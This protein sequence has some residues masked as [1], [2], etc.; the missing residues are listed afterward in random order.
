M[1]PTDLSVVGD[2]QLE[3]QLTA[4]A[5]EIGLRTAR[6]KKLENARA[7]AEARATDLAAATEAAASRSPQPP[8]E[9]RPTT[10]V[11]ASPGGDGAKATAQA[12]EPEPE[13]DLS[14]E[15]PPRSRD[16][17]QERIQAAAERATNHFIDGAAV[18]VYQDQGPWT[19]EIVTVITHE[20]RLGGELRVAFEGKTYSIPSD[21]IGRTFAISTVAIDDVEAHFDRARTGS[22]E[23]NATYSRADCDDARRNLSFILDQATE[24]GFDPK[25]VV[26]SPFCPWAIK[27]RVLEMGFSGPQGSLPPETSRAASV[28][29]GC[30]TAWLD[31]RDSAARERASSG[32]PA[33]PGPYAHLA[34]GR[35][36]PV[37]EAYNLR[38]RLTMNAM[39]K[40]L[41]LVQQAALESQI[42]QLSGRR[43]ELGESS[44]RHALEETD[45]TTSFEV[46][47]SAD[48]SYNGATTSDSN[49]TNTSS[50]GTEFVSAGGETTDDSRPAV[51]GAAAILAVAK[52]GL[53]SGNDHCV[54]CDDGLC[55]PDGRVDHDE[56]RPAEAMSVDG[57]CLPCASDALRDDVLCA[58]C[59][60]QPG[61][62]GVCTGCDQCCIDAHCPGPMTACAAC[63]D[64]HPTDDL[65]DGVC[66]G[67]AQAVPCE[68]CGMSFTQSIGRE[69]VSA[70]YDYD[71]AVTCSDCLGLAERQRQLHEERNRRS[72]WT[73]AANR[74]SVAGEPGPVSQR[75]GYTAEPAAASRAVAAM[76]AM[77]RAETTRPDTIAEAA[78]VLATMNDYAP[79]FLDCYRHGVEWLLADLGDNPSPEGRYQWTRERTLQWKALQSMMRCKAGLSADPPPGIARV[80]AR[81]MLVC[82]QGHVLTVRHP[83]HGHMLPGGAWIRGG[84][85]W[86]NQSGPG[87]ASAGIEQALNL[88][89][90]V[91]GLVYEALAEPAAHSF[92]LAT[93]ANPRAQGG[94]TSRSDT[95]VR[96]WVVR[97]PTRCM[98]AC[99]LRAHE[100]QP[101]LSLF[102]TPQPDLESDYTLGVHRDVNR[103][104]H[105]LDAVTAVGIDECSVHVSRTVN[106]VATL[107][108]VVNQIMHH[109]RRKS[110]LKYFHPVV[111]ADANEAALW[112]LAVR[113]PHN[114]LSFVLVE[115]R[116]L[117]FVRVSPVAA[118]SVEGDELSA[119]P[120]PAQFS[121]DCALRDNES[122][123]G[124]VLRTLSWLPAVVMK[125]VIAAAAE[126]PMATDTPTVGGVRKQK[127]VY[128]VPCW[129]HELVSVVQ[130]S[131][132]AVEEP[133]DQ[134]G[135]G[136]VH[137]ALCTDAE[138]AL[139]SRELGPTINRALQYLP[140]MVPGS[141]APVRA[142]PVFNGSRGDRPL[143]DV[144]GIMLKELLTK[145]DDVVCWNKECNH[146]TV[147]LLDAQGRPRGLSLFCCAKCQRRIAPAMGKSLTGHDE[148]PAGE[149]WVPAD[150]DGTKRSVHWSER[151][152]FASPCT[153][154]AVR[155][156]LPISFN[157]DAFTSNRIGLPATGTGVWK[158][159]IANLSNYD[160]LGAVYRLLGARF[161]VPE[162]S[163][164]ISCVANEPGLGCGCDLLDCEVTVGQTIAKAM[165]ISAQAVSVRMVGSRQALLN[166]QL[167]GCRGR[168][169]Y[170]G[171]DPGEWRGTSRRTSQGSAGRT[172]I[173]DESG[174]DQCGRVCQGAHGQYSQC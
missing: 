72:A 94:D 108:A 57:M 155:R 35:G 54:R 1:E 9:T 121:L 43:S 164:V 36:E 8:P 105:M 83:N 136:A 26:S 23:L 163:L 107:C 75:F 44:L 6:K 125:R 53:A 60:K 88:S 140:A 29:A 167:I 153:I 114:I 156:F 174:V 87:A 39:E 77:A 129:D 27:R 109:L 63:G 133:H 113:H 152:R 73:R 69:A 166:E 66:S 85:S 68:H 154:P 119:K 127:G 47:R 137:L 145:R 124:C 46:T 169:V 159:V 162:D 95:E 117:V 38:A 74:N 142:K 2:A 130:A 82:E 18:H 103:H 120:K 89:V 102:T 56:Q 10:K 80:E 7:L 91:R 131:R 20:S 141:R 41:T 101:D 165:E 55:D 51:T 173:C 92:M 171:G 111:V 106:D 59:G 104:G 134:P 93:A 151:S 14:D 160:D 116:R 17:S 50:E 45:F 49:V 96:V 126:G 112:S 86:E 37:R 84:D 3:A 128:I 62:C 81:V 13:H 31:K 40:R 12:N 138:Q 150:A 147:P 30:A 52:M 135:R 61:H 64:R 172:T 143:W 24:K 149:N 170:T 158:Q 100:H 161:G 21:L 118:K 157:V 123:R 122:A 28:V 115:H 65:A 99:A 5:Q 146:T 148:R 67:C 48:G 79:H 19:G 110:S 22:E 76:E 139:A 34:Q 132:S 16:A 58:V 78:S 32:T 11:G 98:E 42:S 15:I 97:V 33:R 90:E 25:H 4:T 168:R 70:G 71:A 144:T